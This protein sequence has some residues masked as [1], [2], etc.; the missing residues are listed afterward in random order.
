MPQHYKTTNK[1]PEIT[2]QFYEELESV[3][4]G[5]FNAKMKLG[6]KKLY[7][8][9]NKIIGKYG[10][11]MINK[12]GHILLEFAKRNDLRLTNTFFKHKPYPVIVQHG[13]VHNEKVN[14]LLR[15][16][17]ELEE[18]RIT[19]KSIIFLLKTKTK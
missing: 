14:T 10:Q 16:Q 13:N 2:T 9:C 11:G 18:T 8:N 7:E 17:E 19:I 4:G 15:N 6:N 1:I 3:I 5:D 12:N